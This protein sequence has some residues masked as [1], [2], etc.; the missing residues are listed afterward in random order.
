MTKQEL[1][2]QM[3]RECDALVAS[4]RQVHAD[5]WTHPTAFSNLTLHDLVNYAKSW[6][7]ETGNWYL[8]SWRMLPERDSV[9]IENEARQHAMRRRGR[10]VQADL[11]DLANA[12][13]GT[14]VLLDM[15][16]EEQLEEKIGERSRAEQFDDLL[17]T[18]ARIQQSIQA[19][20]G[21]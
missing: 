8:Q 11:T 1:V 19:A 20:T 14:L 17:A 4:F 12:C 15:A 7:E 18:L 5:E 6:L 21:R 13:N 3:R 9:A 2:A 10:E 16:T